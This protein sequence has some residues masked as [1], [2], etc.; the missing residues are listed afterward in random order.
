MS[1]RHDKAGAVL[2]AVKDAFRA[3]FAGAASGILDSVC[4]RRSTGSQ[5][6][7]K[8][9]PPPSNKGMSQTQSK[10]A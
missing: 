7:T 1:S 6:G 2:A 4:A 5:V 8:G 10:I 9:W 3:G